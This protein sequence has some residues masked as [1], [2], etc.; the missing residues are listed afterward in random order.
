ML[1]ENITWSNHINIIEKKI[2]KNIGLLYKARALL[3]KESLKTIYFSYMHSY[4]NYA[5]IAWASTYFTKLKTIHYQQ[6][7]AARIIFYED[8]LTHSRPLLRSL[9]ALNVYQ[10]NLYQHANFMYKFKNNQTP[11]VF[12]DMFEKPSHKYPTRSSEVS[13]TYK[14]FSLNSSKYSISIRGPKIWNELI[15]KDEKEINSFSLF[16]KYVKAKLLESDNERKY[17]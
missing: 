17:F 10:I 5:N 8:I 13:Y 3:N 7:H 16:Q 9:N 14:K 15:T 4:L 12:D 1:D 6:K 2:A 11:K